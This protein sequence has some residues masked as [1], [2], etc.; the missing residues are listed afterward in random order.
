MERL[1]SHAGVSWHSGWTVVAGARVHHVEAGAGP[2]LVL[3]HGGSG[4]GAN[5]FRVLARLA[6]RF[7]VLAPDLPGYGLS[8][9]VPLE[10]PLGIAGAR[11]LDEWVGRQRI[12][13]CH[14]VGTSFGGLMGL[15]YAAAQP[16]RI[17]RLAVLDTVGLGRELHWT[18]RAGSAAP[19][20][21]LLRQSTRRGVE[22]LLRHLLVADA[23]RIPAP[24]RE[25]LIDYLWASDLAAP[26]GSLHRRLRL[27]A[28]WYGQRE[29]ATDRE[30]EAVRS[31][32]LV[33]WGARD[34]MV[35][36][37]HGERAARRM[38]GARLHR[39]ADAGHSPN[40]ET[41]ETVATCLLE[42]FLPTA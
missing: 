9:A 27:F 34:A 7:R 42:H 25:A 10:T 21:P 4:G 32:C 39:I 19:A 18:L 2:P 5:W 14:L 20:A 30:L 12:D 15:R 36:P 37:A 28:T 35:P 38:P 13:R 1:L 17:G 3:L 29:V 16:D 33:V 40:W 11:W 8:Q 24:M 31:P 41:P 26:P 22:W 23:E 6:A